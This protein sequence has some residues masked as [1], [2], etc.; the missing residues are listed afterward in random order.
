MQMTIRTA[1]TLPFDVTHARVVGLLMLLTIPLALLTSFP[2]RLIVP[3]DSA[4]TANQILA[5]E[6]LFR[7]GIVGTLLLM[8]VDAFL[9]V[10]V[11]YQLLKPVNKIVALLMVVLNLLGVA[12]T[13]V[14]ELNYFAIL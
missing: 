11:F 1:E 4:A 6:S 8:I 2:A 13:M 5:S 3:G 10:L 14:N 7:L 9:V 12:I